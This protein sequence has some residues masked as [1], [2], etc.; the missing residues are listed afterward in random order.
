M[1]NASLIQ[2]PFPSARDYKGEEIL[3]LL[4]QPPNNMGGGYAGGRIASARTALLG[5][6]KS[7]S[8]ESVGYL[9]LKSMRSRPRGK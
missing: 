4:K 6:L 8:Y 9:I 3:R 7:Q 2:A 1:P 5:E